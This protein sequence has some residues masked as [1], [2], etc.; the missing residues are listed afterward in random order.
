MLCYVFIFFYTVFVVFACLSSSPCWM[1][2]LFRVLFWGNPYISFIFIYLFVIYL[3]IIY[4]YIYF[5]NFVW[6]YYCIINLFFVK[7]L[8]K[9]RLRGGGEKEAARVTWTQLLSLNKLKFE[10]LEI[11]PH[12]LS[13]KEKRKKWNGKNTTEIKDGIWK[14]GN[15]W[16]YCGGIIL[17][18]LRLFNLN[19]LWNWTFNLEKKRKRK[20]KHTDAISPPKKTEKWV[21]R[22]GKRFCCSRKELNGFGH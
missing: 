14:E 5:F 9:C 3:F 22:R 7:L 16:W 15:K 12:N 18:N 20:R 6:L 4:L 13:N 10:I 17:W 2:C 21:P 1:G 8:L 19:R 11:Y